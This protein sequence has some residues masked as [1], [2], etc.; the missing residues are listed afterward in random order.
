MASTAV[1]VP[2]YRR[3]K[4]T[5]QAFV[6]V[7][8]K[9][10]YLGRYGTPNSKERYAR[11]VAELS[12]RPAI[13]PVVTAADQATITVVEVADA[14]HEFAKGYYRRKD[15]TPSGWLAHIRLM[16]TRHLSGLYGRTPAVE[17]GPRSFKAIRQTLIDAGHSRPYINKLMA[18]IP[19]AFKWAAAEELVPASI[20]HALRT[21]EGLRKG[22][23]TAREPV[24][25]KPVEDTL[26]EATL[27]HLP[28]V[29]AD[30]IRFQRWTG[31]RPGEVCQL[32]PMDLDRSG[33]VWQYRPA[34]HKTEY[35]GRERIIYIGPKAQGIILPYLLREET[36]YCFS[37]AESEAKRHD[38][39]RA[40]RKSRVQPSQWNRRKHRQVRTYRTQYTKDSYA[41]ALRRA[42]DKAN[43]ETTKKA[44][45][46]G[47][48]DPQLLAHWH[49]NQ[50]RHTRATE[51]R[52][53]YG[54]E[55]AQVLL[56]HAKA[57]VTQVYAER[58]NALAVEVTRKI[59]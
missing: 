21:V 25:V 13:S 23:T 10:H 14:Y 59:G 54:L 26:V 7:R 4:G 45:E 6:Q 37:P 15:G 53:Q 36:A 42:I 41:R 20:Y 33:E 24:P 46:A 28:V 11:F 12:S 34:S 18:I 56:G 55:A 47:I 43:R 35:H 38:E 2:K 40:R 48:T 8:G 17:F 19:R 3:H 16:L 5:G 30:M 49:P 31:A 32:R 52:R 39:M 27:P 58:D 22:R 1:S 9:R 51:V 50:L 44:A 29:V 57:D